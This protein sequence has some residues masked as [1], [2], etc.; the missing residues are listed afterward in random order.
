MAPAAPARYPCGRTDGEV[1]MHAPMPSRTL[2]LSRRSLLSAGGLLL[3]AWGM[4]A[5]AAPVQAMVY[6]NPWCGCCN[7]WVDHLERNGFAVTAED[8]DDLAPVKALLGVPAHLES[9]HTAVIEGYTIEGHVPAVAIERLLAAR[10]ALTGLA[11]PGMPMG[12]PGMEGA[13]SEAYDVIAFGPDGESVF[14][15]IPA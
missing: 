14:L 10:P 15:H 4:P 8:T 9:C 6:K 5:L 11:V 2:A 3:A 12:S 7:G 13:T 1:S